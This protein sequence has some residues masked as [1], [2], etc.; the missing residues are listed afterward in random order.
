MSVAETKGLKQLV[1]VLL[2][3]GHGDAVVVVLHHLLPQEAERLRCGKKADMF[4]VKDVGK[5]LDELLGCLLLADNDQVVDVAENAKLMAYP[6]ASVTLQLLKMQL[7]KRCAQ[8]LLP[9]FWCGTQT[10]QGLVETPDDIG[11]LDE[12][13]WWDHED[14]RCDGRVQEGR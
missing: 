7:W 11:V 4:E 6:D 2:G 8:M 5:L 9:K 3:E 10:I 14:L 13:A 1:V 12:L